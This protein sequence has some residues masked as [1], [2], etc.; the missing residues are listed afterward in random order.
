M[1]SLPLF[2]LL[3]FVHSFASGRPERM[4]VTAPIAFTIAGTAGLSFTIQI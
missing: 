2:V 4:I 1:M 3:F